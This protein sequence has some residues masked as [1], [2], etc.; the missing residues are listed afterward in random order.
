MGDAC[1]G[2]PHYLKADERSFLCTKKVSGLEVVDG[3]YYMTDRT[4]TVEL[5]FSM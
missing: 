2:I 3:W 4:K 5:A 1:M